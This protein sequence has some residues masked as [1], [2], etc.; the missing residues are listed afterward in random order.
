M[1]FYIVEC[2]HCQG[3]IIIAQNE[4]NCRIFR[5]GVYKIN[6]QPIHPHAPKIECDRLVQEDLIFGCGKPFFVKDNENSENQQ[7][8][9]IAIECD[10]I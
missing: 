2:P 10:Y 3:T 7:N 6:M 8:H 9:I 4:L 1:D 5:H